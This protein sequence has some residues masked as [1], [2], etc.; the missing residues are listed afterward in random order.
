MTRSRRYWDSSAFLAWLKPEPERANL[1]RGVIRA[2]EKGQLQIV[3]SAVTLTEV[4]K[5]KGSS[6]LKPQQEED[7]E[8][9]FQKDYIL[10]RNLDRFVA[11]EA[12]RLM[13]VYSVL[14]AKDSIHLAAAI[15]A[16]IPIFDTFD[17]ELLNL[18]GKFSNKIAI[19]RPYMLEQQELFETISKDDNT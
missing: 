11:E 15:S 12:R 16:K 2:A 9:F 7:I 14:K 8:R 5:L 1:C 4:I 13:W 3:T 18:N 6:K 17:C 10:V 19:K